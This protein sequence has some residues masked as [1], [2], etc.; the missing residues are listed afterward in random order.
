MV[1]YESKRLVV[2]GS[3]ALLLSGEIHYFRV[4]RAQWQDRIDKAKAAGLDTVATYIPWIWH[5]LPDGSFD[6]TG[7][8]RP[9]RDLGAFLDLCHAAGLR[10]IARP[11]P[12]VMA[13][14]KNEGL[15]YRLYRQHPQIVPTGWDG[16]PA[17]TR[18]VDYLAP[19]FLAEA[20]RWY[21]AVMPVIAAR[22]RPAGGPVVAVQL[23][24]EVG[25]LAWVSNSPDLTDHLTDDFHGWLRARHGDALRE[26]YPFADA[27]PADRR[28]AVRQPQDGYAATLMNDLGRFMRGRFARYVAELRGC[29]E[30]LGVRG[31]PFVVNIH[32][33]ADGR[34]ETFPIGISQLM[35]TYAGVPGMI[36]GSDIYLGD[37]TVANAADLYLV[38]AFMD[39][40]HDDQ[41]PLSSVEFEAGD[42]DYGNTL[43]RQTDP[44]AVDLKTRMCLAQGNRLLNYYLFAGGV[45]P[46]LDE[47]VGDGNDRLAFTGERH[48]FAAPVGPEGQLSPGYEPL[49]RVLRTVN[50]LRPHLAAQREEHDAVALGFVPDHY[51][52]E[53]HHPDSPS[54]AAVRDE[55]T[56]TR[57]A[58]PGGVLARAML[59]GGFRFGSLDL[60]AARPDPARHPVIALAVAEHLPAAVQHHLTGYLRAG[61]RLL[62]AGRVPDKDMT[63]RP[64]TVLRDALGLSPLGAV[65]DTGHFF[66]SV[67]AH[68]WAAPRPETR[69]GR[70][71]LLAAERGE[72]VLRELSTGHGCGFDVPVGAGRAVVV[73]ADYP[74][75]LIL[76]RAAFAALGAVPRLRHTSPVPGLI[77][78]SGADRAGGRLLHALNVTGYEQ[79][80]T[81]TDGELPLF[82]GESVRLPGRRALM[83]PLDL[84]V[85]PLRLA[86]STAEPVAVTGSAVTF[87]APARSA[88]LAV[89]GPASCADPRVI[90]EPRPGLTLLRADGAGE[91]TVL[92]G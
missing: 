89:A 64:C 46:P 2:D 39:A 55:V 8:T 50:A 52:T 72:T 74:C 77:L 27:P 21:R 33:T 47:P 4:A 86:W 85:G 57:G 36:S 32:G 53:Y 38:N 56:G 3:D 11:G 73:S 22:L 19:A 82:G 31:V 34:A 76:W 14:L 69:A 15:P 66:P 35:E 68:G 63:G 91:F 37:L 60:Q 41:Q 40:V 88:V 75:D 48:G 59:L 13:E 65:R 83:L 92:A 43:A 17:P 81:V 51:L 30:Q 87:H 62:L 42:G 6:L 70:V 80:F 67:T 1:H 61:G 26:R 45:N 24:N 7:E 84:T 25:M 71:Q 28:A 90:A 54:A 12:F 78:L 5:E 49:A 79:E 44:S 29:A 9:E 18:T 58:G 10:V 20:R 16:A 23:D